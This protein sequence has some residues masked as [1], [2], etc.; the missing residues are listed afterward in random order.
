[1]NEN[2]NMRELNL[3][4]LNKVVGGIS[5]ADEKKIKELVE[6]CMAAEA[7]GDEEQ[8]EILKAKYN[9]F[10]AKLIQKYGIGEVVDYFTS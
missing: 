4:Q 10:I 5:S 8:F 9:E 1:M 6:A 2:K 3:D 7:A